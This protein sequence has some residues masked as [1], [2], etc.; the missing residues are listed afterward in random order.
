MASLPGLVA[1]KVQVEAQ[2]EARVLAV[3]L[4]VQVLVMLNPQE[5]VQPLVEVKVVDPLPLV[6]A[7]QPPQLQVV[8]VALLLLV[9]Q[10]QVQLVARV[11]AQV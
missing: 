2:L 4:E 10:A 1:D 8:E 9:A 7:A 3:M 5:E 6:Q 11:L